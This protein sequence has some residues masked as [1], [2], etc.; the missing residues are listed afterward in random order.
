MKGIILFTSKYGTAEKYARWLAEETGFD[1]AETK[2]A[3]AASLSGYDTVVFGGGIYAGRIAGLGFLK[4]NAAALAGKRTVIYCCGVSEHTEESFEQLKAMNLKDGL[5]GTPCFYLRGAF[6]M[7]G[8]KFGDRTLCRMLIKMV[9]KKAPDDLDVT[10]RAILN[11]KD[12]AC[13][14][15]GKAQLQ[16][17]IK[18][19]NDI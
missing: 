14:F 13:D 9:S 11:V 3:D 10:E 15:T 16:E 18:C 19:I 4:K 5:E 7:N 12:K 1:C 8:L 2:K 6:D 17:I